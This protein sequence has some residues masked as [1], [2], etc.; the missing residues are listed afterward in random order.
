M[1]HITRKLTWLT[2]LLP[3]LLP[4]PAQAQIPVQKS[5]LH[6]LPSGTYTLDKYHASLIWKIEHMGLSHYAGRFTDFAATVDFNPLAP[7]KSKLIAK[8]NPA[9]LETD[10]RSEKLDFNKELAFGET[11]FNAGKF[12]KITFESTK[13]TITGEKTGKIEG[14]LTFLG[15][16]KPVILDVT[17]NGGY[18]KMPFTNRPTIGFSATAKINRSEWGMAAY[19]DALGETVNIQIE[20][21]F[22]Q[23]LPPKK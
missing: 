23:N 19:P 10:Y 16:T 8:I 21:E 12:S 4:C 11:W 17:F 9:S 1:P 7:E 20:A 5:P 18:R 15:V 6:A 22:N 2:I 14:N 3:L 13:I